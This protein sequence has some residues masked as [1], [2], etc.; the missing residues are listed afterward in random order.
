M[1]KRCWAF[2]N[3]W[4]FDAHFW[5]SGECWEQ[6]IVKRTCIF[7]FIT[8]F[9]KKIVFRIKKLYIESDQIHTQFWAVVSTFQVQIVTVQPLIC[10]II[11]MSLNGQWRWKK[12]TY[13]GWLLKRYSHINN[14]WTVF[15]I[16]NTS[17]YYSNIYIKL[18]FILSKH[19]RYTISIRN[20]V[21]CSIF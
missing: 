10:F 14:C 2:A 15:F 11:Q 12:S 16:P 1:N 9:F 17:N 13:Y 21:D 7:Q 5:I 19:Q 20:I 3:V 8:S 4:T 18:S 6:L